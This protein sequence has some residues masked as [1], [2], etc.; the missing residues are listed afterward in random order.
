MTCFS[1]ISLQLYSTVLN[2][3]RNILPLKTTGDPSLPQLV[4]HCSSVLP[5]LSSFHLISLV[6]SL[7]TIKLIS[8][9]KC[10]WLRRLHSSVFL[11][12]FS[13]FNGFRSSTIFRV[14]TGLLGALFVYYHRRIAFFKKRNRI[15]QA[16][17]G[18]R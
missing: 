3:H 10:L 15:F 1:T 9:M 7:P 11:G 14:M 5:S 6:Q 4:L 16:L 18:K 8:Q 2:P 12:Q 17:F 13:M